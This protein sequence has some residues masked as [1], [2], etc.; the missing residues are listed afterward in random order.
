MEYL[1]ETKIPA[2]A[3]VRF[4]FHFALGAPLQAFQTKHPLQRYSPRP[5]WDWQL[6]QS[7]T[8]KTG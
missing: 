6:L 3:Q 2:G 8:I 7:A 5:C 1:T 4:N